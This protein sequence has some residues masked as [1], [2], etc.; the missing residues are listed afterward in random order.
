MA[1]CKGL[2]GKALA[3]CK[4]NNP[5]WKNFRM[6]NAARNKSEGADTNRPAKK[7]DSV[8]YKRGYQMGLKRLKPTAKSHPYGETEFEKMGRWEGQNTKY[9]K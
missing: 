1:D 5:T 9:K 3:D 7:I 2:K 6:A 4:K 8:Q